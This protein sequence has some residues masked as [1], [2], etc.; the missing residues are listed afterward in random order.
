MFVTLVTELTLP[1]ILTPIRALVRTVMT[2]L[3]NTEAEVAVPVVSSSARTFLI[4]ATTEV[5]LDMVALRALKA[6]SCKTRIESRSTEVR[7][8]FS[9][10]D[11]G[12]VTVTV[13]TVST[14]VP[15]L[16]SMVFT[17]RVERLMVTPR[18]R[19]R[20]AWLARISL[21]TETT[22]ACSPVTVASRVF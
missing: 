11:V 8:T 13:E 3:M 19:V 12:S 4:T 15:V 9:V 14:I 6:F 22:A 17:V 20:L 18:S 5:M 1:S 10:T 21:V 16:T 2:S 7:H